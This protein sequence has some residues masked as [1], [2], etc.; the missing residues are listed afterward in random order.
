MDVW[1]C[2]A[3]HGVVRR[4]LEKLLVGWCCS[5]VPFQ[6]SNS[7]QSLLLERCFSSPQIKRKHKAAVFAQCLTQP[8]VSMVL[9][10]KQ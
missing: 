3:E 9:C 10:K 2:G 6:E 8:S 4:R 5:R 1:W 7:H